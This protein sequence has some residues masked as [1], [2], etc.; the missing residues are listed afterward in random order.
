[1]VR[2]AARF[3]LGVV[4][5]KQRGMREKAAAHEQQRHHPD[6]AVEGLE[7]GRGEVCVQTRARRH[8]SLWF[9]FSVGVPHMTENG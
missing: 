2:P 8:S 6:V 7:V 4:H 9:V 1:M 5:I 3:L